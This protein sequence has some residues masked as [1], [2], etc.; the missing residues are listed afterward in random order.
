MS[1]LIPFKHEYMSFSEG[2]LDEKLAYDRYSTPEHDINKINIGDVVVCK[3]DKKSDKRIIGI[4]I[5]KDNIEEIVVR[6]RVLKE[7]GV[8]YELKNFHYELVTKPLDI[9]P[10]DFW[11]RWAKSGASVENEVKKEEIENNF[12]WLFDGFSYSP[13]GR[14]Q[15]S[16]GQEF[17][18]GSKVKLS[19]FNCFVIPSPEYKKNDWDKAATDKK[20]ASKALEAV[21]ENAINEAQ[22]MARGGGVGFNANTIP[23]KILGASS[24]KEDIILYLPKEH[25]DHDT[26]LD[27]IKL[28]KFSHVTL[29]YEK[30]I[31]KNYEYFSVE[32]SREGILNGTKW[33]AVSIYEGKKVFLDFSNIRYK[34]SLVKGV[35]GRSSGAPS[36]MFLYNVIAQLLHMDFYDA[37]DAMEIQ[38]N[39]T[40]LIEQGGSRRGALMIVL[41]CD[42]PNI[43]KFIERKQTPGYIQGAN[44]SVGI[45]NA[46]MEK[47]KII[48]SEESIVWDMII[49]SAWKSAEPGVLFIEYANSESNSFYF[50]ELIATNPCGEQFLPA[51]GVCNLGHIVLSRFYDEKLNDVNYENLRRAIHYGVRFQDNI[52]TY[53]NYFIPENQA[54]QESERR[55]GMGTMGLATLKLKLGIR[56]GSEESLAFT[57]KLFKFIAIEAYKASIDL[58]E[59]KGKFPKCEPKKMAKSGFMMRLLKEMPE[60]YQNK[61]Y[62]F[63]IRNVTILTQAPTGSTGTYI[64]NLLM[65]YGDG[66]STGIEPYFAFEYYRASR[67]GN[68]VKQELGL[69][70]KW[71]EENPNKELPFYFVT[72]QDLTPKDHV[73][74]Q[75]A[76]QKWVDSSISKTANCPE[77]F[78]VED[79]KELYNLAY[80]L[81]CKGVTIYRDNSRDAQV[82]STDKDGARLESDIEEQKLNDLKNQKELELTESIAVTNQPNIQIVN[83]KHHLRYVNGSYE[84]TLPK[85]PKRLKGFTEQVL[86]QYGDYTGKAYVTI[87]S[88]NGNESEEVWEVFI[89]TEVKEIS[90][91][92]KALGLMITKM[93]RYGIT[94]DNLE[95]VIE[96]LSFD[97]TYGTLP[98]V[99]AN[100]L[101]GIQ[102]EWLSTEIIPE[103]KVKNPNKIKMLGLSKCPSCGEQTFDK[104]NCECK[105]PDCGISKCN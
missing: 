96:S 24:K 74:V 51:W 4:L 59:E 95:I 53:T 32:D 13:G 65:Q 75:A 94:N 97:Q 68:S 81:G 27:M 72:A 14:I 54:Q 35:N 98:S 36:W 43:R 63:G 76:I 104:A 1:N 64:D 12:R 33:M 57:D 9:N 66:T 86:F 25:P 89:S 56:Y 80:D 93:L 47:T 99:V 11:S 78:T 46:F 84:F 41:M 39:I 82:L 83:G 70:K 49:R 67:S 6:T 45:T 105:H 38:S 79:T 15:L 23:S 18:N 21:I 88:F 10:S 2:G 100:L 19:G 40:S 28:E 5:N 87:N 103:T 62:K 30:N 7:E 3:I 29:V 50:A 69:V 61:F 85:R 42:H 60:E 92:A 90:S 22:I 8:H 55:I 58:A 52:I 37:V 20:Y 48:G 26:L 17:R 34:G 44:I 102:K 16:A 31:P 71:R 101:K 91:I 73:R 77:D